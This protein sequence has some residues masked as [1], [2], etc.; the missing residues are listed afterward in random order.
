MVS[1]R[2]DGAST[3]P[4]EMKHLVQYGHASGQCPSINRGGGSDIR[5][6]YTEALELPKCEGGT[7]YGDAGIRAIS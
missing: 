1:G 2:T 7:A 5:G 4:D 3:R 6:W